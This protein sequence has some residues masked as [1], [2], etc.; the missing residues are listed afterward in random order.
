MANSRRGRN[1]R[2]APEGAEAP[3]TPLAAWPRAA[4]LGPPCDG[5][6][7]L[8]DGGKRASGPKDQPE[9]RSDGS[10]CGARSSL[11]LTANQPGCPR[12]ENACD[13]SRDQVRRSPGPVPAAFL[14]FGLSFAPVALWAE[15]DGPGTVHGT[16]RGRRRAPKAHA[17]GRARRW[18]DFARWG[19]QRAWTGRTGLRLGGTVPRTL[20]TPAAHACV[21]ERGT[22][23]RLA[24]WR[25]AG[26]HVLRVRAGGD[27]PGGPRLRATWGRRLNVRRPVPSA[28]RR[29]RAAESLAAGDRDVAPPWPWAPLARCVAAAPPADQLAVP[30]IASLHASCL[31]DHRGK[32]R[33][34][35]KLRNELQVPR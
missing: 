12:D 1:P 29:P 14:S 7:K 35:F 21:C 27:C 26:W 18:R 6:P 15:R 24:D 13:R 11:D 30:H 25:L 34:S 9:R 20:R 23:S 28:S 5:N 10:A 4:W 19:P 16:V 2:T 3:R 8:P 22:A 33:A 32:G 17:R 31:G